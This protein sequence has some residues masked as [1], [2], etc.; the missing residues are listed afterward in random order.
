MD[1]RVMRAMEVGWVVREEERDAGLVMIVRGELSELDRSPLMLPLTLFALPITPLVPLGWDPD[2][3][4]FPLTGP[5]A[6]AATPANKPPAKP[7]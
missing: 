3:V 6:W 1:L 4:A 5:R 7:F 2:D